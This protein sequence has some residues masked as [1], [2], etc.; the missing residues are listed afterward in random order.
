MQIAGN[1]V[2]AA[3]TQIFKDPT[4]KTANVFWQVC[5]CVCSV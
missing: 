2:Q 4:L 3:N 5:P 1:L